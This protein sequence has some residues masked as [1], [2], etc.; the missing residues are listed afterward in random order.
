V[1]EYWVVDLQKEVV[2]VMRDPDDGE[3]RS[4]TTL[5]FYRGH[6]LSPQRFPDVE[7]ELDQL[8]PRRRDTT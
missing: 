4:L 2:R 8:V 3:Y 1:P 6:R 7:L 5:D